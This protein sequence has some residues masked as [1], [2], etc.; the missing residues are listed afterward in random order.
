MR[1]NTHPTVKPTDLMRWLV[2]L[3]TRPGGLVMDPFCGSG[4]T[5]RGC[6]MEGFRFVGIE[7][8]LESCEIARDR[9]ISAGQQLVLPI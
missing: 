9:I 8:D 5:G 7:R 2:R 1:R 4:S 6:A 3:V